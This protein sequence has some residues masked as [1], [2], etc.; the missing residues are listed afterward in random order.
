MIAP[1]RCDIYVTSSALQIIS[2]ES[3]KS[4]D[5]LTVCYQRCHRGRLCNAA[6]KDSN[7]GPPRYYFT[8]RKIG[9]KKK[10]AIFPLRICKKNDK[11]LF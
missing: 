6:E 2:E 9:K 11:L 5:S 1:I 3:S 7:F 10:E 8:P 4:G